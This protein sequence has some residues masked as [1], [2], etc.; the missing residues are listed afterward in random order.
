MDVSGGRGDTYDSSVD[1]SGGVLTLQ[2]LADDV[3]EAAQDYKAAGKE[4][5]QAKKE[6]EVAKRAEAA[7]KEHLDAA[8]E[9]LVNHCGSKRT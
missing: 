6:Y 8:N 9:L 1:R 3:F 4:T 2:E 7:A 5:K